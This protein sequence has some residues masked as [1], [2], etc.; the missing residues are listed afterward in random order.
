VRKKSSIIQGGY[1]A[2][3]HSSGSE[4]SPRRYECASM[5]DLAEL[6]IQNFYFYENFDVLGPINAFENLAKDKI[7]VKL[8]IF[9]KISR[10]CIHVSPGSVD[11]SPE[12]AEWSLG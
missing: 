6:A 9:S 1:E 5:K 7:F 3:Q 11:E 8:F 10:F 2:I 4:L 12:S